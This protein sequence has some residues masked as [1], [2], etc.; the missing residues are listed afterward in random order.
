MSSYA[1][2]AGFTDHSPG[3][4]LR[5]MPH[6]RTRVFSSS[7]KELLEQ[8]VAID[9]APPALIDAVKTRRTRVLQRMRDKGWRTLAVVSPG[10][11]EGRTLVAVNLAVSIAAQ[12]DQ[13]ALLVD[14]DLRNP[15]IG[16][17][18]GVPASP[19]LTE[20]LA[21]GVPVH[22]T[23]SSPGID[24]LVL[25]P[26][27]RPVTRSAEWLGS[28]RMAGLMAELR[29][30]YDDRIVIV[31]LPPLL[32]AADA[33]AFTPMADAILL[34]AEDNRSARED[35]VAAQRMLEG[36]N[37]IGIVLNKSSRG[38]ARGQARTR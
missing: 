33:L 2:L 27:G 22:A 25:M 3:T 31:D 7:E 32:G 13:T 35:I 23:L 24:R 38:T 17:V 9:G 21:H 11:G 16:R 26:A 37:V 6:P 30:R 20:I 29:N 5:A 12:F 34:V 4:G 1:S 18:F 28:V 36:R 10:A 15:S 19:G 8:K 14:A